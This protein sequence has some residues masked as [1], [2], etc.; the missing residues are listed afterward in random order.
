[1]KGPIVAA[2]IENLVDVYCVN[3]GSIIQFEPRTDEARAWF[4]ENVQSEGWQWLGN[5][6]CIEPRLADNLL[7]GI[8]EA[9]LTTNVGV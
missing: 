5:R 7:Q 3:C 9:G 8:I 2:P 6:L 4:D 1:M